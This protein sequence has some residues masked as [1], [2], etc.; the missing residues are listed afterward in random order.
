MLL[1]SVSNK[2]R[3]A[4]MYF[5]GLAMY[6]ILGDKYRSF[7]VFSRRTP[8]TVAQRIASG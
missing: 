8:L 5:I 4:L 2:M 1:Y 7:T 3:S 6:S